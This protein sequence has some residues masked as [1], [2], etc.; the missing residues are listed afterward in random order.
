MADQNP[1]FQALMEKVKALEAENVALK[2]TPKST[3][4]FKIGVSAKG[5]VSI[6]GLQRFPVTL[7]ASQWERVLEKA[8]EL[9]AFIAAN[10]AKL[11]RKPA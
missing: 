7:Y 5:A 8:P 9:R 6:Y 2:A 4:P 3:A 10:A 1:S 11:L